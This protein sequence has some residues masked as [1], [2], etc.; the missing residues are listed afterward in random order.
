[1]LANQDE[2]IQYIP[3]RTPI[4]MV[5][6]LVEASDDH[7]VTQLAIDPANI[8][9]KDGQ[10][11]EPGL[12]ENIAQTAAVHVGYQCSKK[13]IPIPIGYIAAVKS[14]KIDVLPKHNTT[15]TTSVEIVNKVLDITVV[16][17][18][19]EQEGKVLASCEMRIFAKLQS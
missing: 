7:A 16:Q 14:L 18:K 5:H 3:Q 13:N 15:I 4:V 8:F 6:N 10:F 11:M 19:V 12:V 2:I 1:M 9:V 17:G